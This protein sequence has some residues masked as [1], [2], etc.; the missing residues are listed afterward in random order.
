MA[1]FKMNYDCKEKGCFNEA[2]RLKFGA[3]KDCLPRGIQFTDIDGFVEVDNRFLFIEWKN[4]DPR[5]LANGQR[6]AYQQLTKA[7]PESRLLH[8]C[9]DARTMESTHLRVIND[10]KIGAWRGCPTEYL[11]AIHAWGHRQPEREAA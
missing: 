2:H 11:S 7:L 4:G 1:S 3:F 6:W 5:E 10:G 8:I 9:G